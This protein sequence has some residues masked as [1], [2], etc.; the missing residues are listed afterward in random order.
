MS[1]V[2]MG[3]FDDPN[4]FNEKQAARYMGV[5]L[6]TLRRRRAARREPAFIQLDRRILYR[7]AALDKMLDDHTVQPQDPGPE[8]TQ[9]DEQTARKSRRG[10]KKV[11]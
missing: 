2:A 11:Q 5:S 10:R 9:R 8:E 3:I 4:T 7:K 1:S 6:S